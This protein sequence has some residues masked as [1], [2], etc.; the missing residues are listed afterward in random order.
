MYML[1]TANLMSIVILAVSPAAAENG[2]HPPGI[3]YSG[4][5][6]P[7]PANHVRCMKFV[8]AYL[9]WVRAGVD[10]AF[11]LPLTRAV[12]TR[13]YVEVAGMDWGPPSAVTAA[14][15]A[16]KSEAEL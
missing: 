7:I 1:R 10:G 6:R 15:M 8:D 5:A 13:T 12:A 3:H 14:A 2:Y 16:A 4:S 9:T 11:K